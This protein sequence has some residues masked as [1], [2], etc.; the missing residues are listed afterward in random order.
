M[1]LKT[2]LLVEADADHA[3]L[4]CRAFE[5]RSN[6]FSVEWVAGLEAA[7][8]YL[9]RARPDLAIIDLNL[10]DGSGLDLLAPGEGEN[11][12]PV[13][14]L[15]TPGD[16]AGAEAALEA[17]AVDYAV[18]SAAPGDD[19]PA[20]AE[21]ALQ[22]WVHVV[23]GRRA[24]TS[25]QLVNRTLKLLSECN[26]ALI[27][28]ADESSLLTEICR[29]VVEEGG[30]RLA[31]VGLIET[32]EAKRVRPAAQA[33]FEDG[34]L[35]SLGLTWADTERGRSPTGRA[36]RGGRPAV[37]R[38]IRTDPD[39]AIWR[40]EALARGY[41][42]M[43]SLP[44][45]AEKQ[46]FGVLNLYSPRPDAFDEGE[47]KLLGQLAVDLS[48]GV[49]TLRTRWQHR[50][51]EAALSASE[52][53]Y[54]GLVETM[55]EGLAV[56]DENG[57]VVYVN[58]QLG[59]IVGLTP[60]EIIGRPVAG[61]LDESS[62]K[63]WQAQPT[64]R[65]QAAGEPYEV[66]TVQP[67]GP[68][69]RLLVSPRAIFGPDGR[70]Q[71]SFA[72]ITDITELKRTQDVLAERERYYRTLMHT[73][74]EDILV[75]DRD[76][77]IIDVNNS[78]L[79]TMGVTRQEVIGRNCYEVSHGFDSPC[80]EHGLAC[81]LREVFETGRPANY[82]HEHRHGDGT[83]RVMDVLMSPLK[84]ETGRVNQVIEAV[85]DV[86]DVFRAREAL[87]ASEERYR[88]LF[89]RSNDA[90][91]VH[92]LDDDGRPGKFVEVND[93]A[94]E[95]LGYTREE[96][97]AMSP[98]DIGVGV[99]PDQVRALGRALLAEG[100]ARFETAHRTKDGRL[101]PVESNVR[102]VDLR[103]Q[104]AV[105][106]VSRDITKRKQAEAARLESQQAL[107]ALLDATTESAFLI[108][109]DYE[110]LVCNRIAA[111]R[112]GSTPD[113]LIGRKLL[114]LFPE[115][116]AARRRV[117]FDELI[118]TG[119]PVRQVDTRGSY[120]FDMSSYPV[121]DEAGR[122]VR[123]AV[124]ARDVTESRRA[125]AALRESEARFRDLFDSI[126]DWICVHDLEGRLL[127][128]NPVVCQA[129]GYTADELIGRLISDFLLPE[130]RPE[131][132]DLYL[133]QIKEKGRFD[134][135]F[136]VKAKDGTVRYIEYSNTLV[137]TEGREPFVSGVGRDVTERRRAARA[138]RRSEEQYRLVVDHAHEGICVIQDGIIKFTNPKLAEMAGL[139][140]EEAISRSFIDYIHPEDRP[141]VLDRYQRR[142]AG[143]SFPDHHSYRLMRP[144]GVVRWMD[145]IS[146]VV[147]WERR[148]ATINFISD[149]TDQR[150]AE[151]A[152]R[153]SEEQY[154]L[155]VDNA[156]EGI[157]IAQDGLIQFANPKITEV[158]GYPQDELI[159][160]RF[161]EFIHPEDRSAVEERYR[162]ETTGQDPPGP[163]PCR[164]V[165]R[166]GEVRWVEMHDV[167]IQWQDRP[168]TLIFLSDVT[169]Q[170]LAQA[171]KE[172][173]EV[174]F[175]QA[176]K[177]E[178]VGR[179]AGG[180][181]HDF[182]N[183]LT[184]ITG[185]SDLALAK[186][187]P[188]DPLHNDLN[189]INDA[190]QRAA[191][192]TRQLLTFS[193]QQ[194]IE[195][196]TLDPRQVVA[197]VEHMLR[198][199]I[200]ED[201][202][203]VVTADPEAGAV[204]ADPGQL[205][206]VLMNLAINARDA[207]ERGGRLTI[208]IA[209]AFLDEDYAEDHLGVSPGPHVMLA[210]SDTGVG[211]DEALRS[212]IFDP[213]FTTKE[214][215]KGT[216]LGLATVYGIVKQSGGHITVYSE[217][218][219]GST[220]KVYLPRTGLEAGRP[221]AADGKDALRRGTE[222]VLVVEDEDQ[223]RDLAS[224]ILRRQGYRVLEAANGGEAILVCEQHQGP[225]HL[226]LTDVIM[227]RM[228]GQ[229]LAERIRSLRPEA[230]FLFMSGY[231]DEAIARHGVLD[232]GVNFIGKPFSAV[233]LA[234]KVRE[235][236]DG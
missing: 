193:R 210:V 92:G 21:R 47:V 115:E 103:G 107:T 75:L 23:A 108:G 180:I 128:V 209:N 184:I 213:F 163:R 90:I 118:R 166:D 63:T 212:K 59:R 230:K 123:I 1:A 44:L 151:E 55:S 11:P 37:C 54:R 45:L 97:L 169:D 182:N 227:P 53:K 31:W 16:E 158:L 135:V 91:F 109:T 76:Y 207:M 126:S 61:F 69:R 48:Y 57:V 10:G 130:Y 195:P 95:R 199:L 175:Q 117:K 201:I 232:E 146:V 153:R 8:R 167:P 3:G 179:L 188:H 157:L 78:F 203:L 34:Y 49:M 43:I 56:A 172:N 66:T 217:P 22:K 79:V 98:L 6:G 119:R 129:S 120:I 234:A 35:D 105:L 87:E 70:F 145:V 161:T 111:E 147:T 185:Y 223:V 124:F 216:G 178:A 85:R 154:R 208:Q 222:T 65:G 4:V 71:G 104:R 181:A 150:E 30:Y 220:F 28:A 174:Q 231:T 50:R 12:F 202:E 121:L 205:E 125:A 183:L 162:C 137:T 200:G 19:L 9:S 170:R 113:Q 101:V 94:C 189:E 228:S 191:A 72:V 100:H 141:E 41:A 221:E 14:V 160:R 171:E 42:S 80:P 204:E 152:L 26:Q 40:E 226:T 140:A 74:H 64:R 127:S 192:L 144:D 67:D 215:G 58:N 73:I 186:T 112:L 7:R 176:Q 24:Q 96:L 177:M 165:R 29:L 132:L 68:Q 84:D 110:I 197:N 164:A 51:A 93:V 17:G 114:D 25:L 236:L 159:S 99:D 173:M 136:R 143:E 219:R 13:V 36:I 214:T 229:D 52:A 18:K 89:N 39:F 102:L 233:K 83:I 139:T 138:L 15:T 155:V 122:L 142:L 235:I 134:G 190:G 60:D 46:T 116:V 149:I 148:P 5:D 168:A 206:Q 32:D 133:T 77:R 2:I 88:L 81:P 225:I 218:G 156:H 131:F 27:R 86:S 211:M 198:R 196:Q 194:V 62:R 33:G 82:Y 224:R 20:M 187:S 38:N 106:S